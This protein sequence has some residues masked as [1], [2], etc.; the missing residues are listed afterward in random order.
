VLNH[1]QASLAF[2]P[3]TTTTNGTAGLVVTLRQANAV[4][5]TAARFT[6]AYPANLVNA[7][8]PGSFN[9]CPG[10]VVTAAAGGAS[11]A[12][13]AATIPVNGCQVAVGVASAVAGSYTVT[14]PAGGLG[15]ANAGGNSTAASATLSVTGR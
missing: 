14:L 10:A 4:P 15:T 7:N 11:L 1:F 13:S 2:V 9:T 5:I 12:V 3:G 8:L 6:L